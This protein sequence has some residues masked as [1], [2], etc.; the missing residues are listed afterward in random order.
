MD[1]PNES[2]L[3]TIGEAVTQ[4]QAAYP[5]ISHSSLRF[6]QR[7]GMVEPMRTVGGHRLYTVADLDRVRR[8]KRWQEHRLSLQEI[9][10]R[11]AKMDALTPPAQLA[12]RFLDL[13]AEG[14]MEAAAEVVLHADELGQGLAETFEQVLRPVLVEIG[15]RWV[16][17]AFSIA[18]EH[19]I[20]ELTR[21]IV[22]ELSNRHAAAGYREPVVL[23]TCVVDELHDLGLRMLCGILRQRGVRL[24]YL[25]ADVSAPY[26]VEAVHLRRPHIVLLSV[27]L[28]E[29]LPALR[30]SLLAISTEPFGDRRPLV[31]GGGR[32]IGH[33]AG[34]REALGARVVTQVTLEGAA[35]AILETWRPASTAAT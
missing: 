22:A 34:D 19:E 8:I 21:E 16:A 15:E 10:Q 11:L 29:H 31:V 12:Q 27:S 18:Q 14:E 28:A 33:H 2:R 4:L 30:E 3:F 9:R 26:L 20:T 17:A 35:D 7:E 24:H 13:A 1:A 6:L 32:G 5:D 25:G 23:A